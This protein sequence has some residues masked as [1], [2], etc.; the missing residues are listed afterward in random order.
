MK[1][2]LLSA[3]FGSRLRPLTLKI[4]KCLVPIKG[5]P[6]LEIWLERLNNESLGPFLV[7]THYLKKQVEDF[8]NESLLNDK[9]SIVYEPVL[10][11]TAGTLMANIDFFD[12]KDGLLIHADNYCLADFNEFVD[13]HNNRPSNCLLTMMTFKTETPHT[14]GI[15]ELDCNNIVKAIHEK[16]INPPGNLANGAVYILSK[17]LVTLL[18]ESKSTLVDF[19]SQVLPKLIGKIYTYETSEIF[20]DIGVKDSYEK[21]NKL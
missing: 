18:K 20:I 8:V 3:G 6:L 1:A 12:G 11:G 9:V 5:V 21:A 19:S 10:L 17:E 13:A 15:I 16:V 2:I 14:C 7:N 4:P